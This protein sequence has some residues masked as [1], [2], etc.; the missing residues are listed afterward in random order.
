MP[1]TD[2]EI[3]DLYR[4]GL[5]DE[6]HKALDERGLLYGPE[7]QKAAEPSSAPAAAAPTPSKWAT[8]QF[9]V[10]VAEQLIQSIAE[11]LK[12]KL[13]REL[14]PVREHVRAVYGQLDARQESSDQ[15]LADFDKRVAELERRF[16]EVEGKSIRRVA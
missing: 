5:V 7:K 6:W 15:L 16:S 8:R 4:R 12:E 9:V 11:V 3:G 13:E 10:R 2:K 14:A 1:L